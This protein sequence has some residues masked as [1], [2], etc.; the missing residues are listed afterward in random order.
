[1]QIPMPQSLGMTVIAVFYNSCL[2]GHEIIPCH[3]AKA[4]SGGHV[5]DVQAGGTG[6]LFPS[7]CTQLVLLNLPC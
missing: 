7:A 5:C 1:M 4:A 2:W 6:V 3:S